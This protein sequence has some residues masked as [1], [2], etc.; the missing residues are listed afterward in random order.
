MLYLCLVLPLLFYK[1]D[2]IIIGEFQLYAIRKITIVPIAAIIY[3]FTITNKRKFFTRFILFFAIGQ[4][5]HLFTQDFG[6]IISYFIINGLFII[7]YLCLLIDLCS[8]IQLSEAIKKFRTYAAVLFILS[9]YVILTLQIVTKDPESFDYIE[10]VYNTLVV[11]VLSAS[12]LHLFYY[13]DKKSLYLLL[14]S[15]ILTIHEFSHI[16]Y[17]Y[18]SSRSGIYLFLGDFL[19]GVAFFFL[20]KQA[21]LTYKVSDQFS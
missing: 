1:T 18:L 20:I 13:Y 12:L 17:N 4:F 6:D 10:A 14:G 2:F 7:G 19:I 5:L 16:A 3:F 21:Q 11:T 9:I 15:L 8:S